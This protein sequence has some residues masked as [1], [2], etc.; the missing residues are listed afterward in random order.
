MKFN[1]RKIASVLTSAVML[2]STLA[3]AAAANY[4]APFVK[5]GNANVAI[6]YGSTAA[7]TDLVAVADISSHLSSELAKQTA[8]TGSSSSG[9]SVSGGDFVKLAKSSNNVNLR[10]TVSSVFG[11]IVTDDDLK[12]LLADGT[13]SND[14]NTEYDYE[15][16]VTLG[17]NLALTFFSDNDYKDEEATVG[18][19]LSSSETVLN[20]TLDFTT[21]AESDIVSGDLPDF[22]TTT[23][24]IL[25]K[26]Y[27][28]LDAKNQSNNKLTLLD[29]ANNAIVA[30]GETQTVTVGDKSYEVSIEFISTTQTKL[31]INGQVTNT[32]ANGGTY[33]LSDGT[34]VGVKDILARDVAGSVGKVEFSLGTG[35]LELTNAEAIELNDDSI[36]EIK[37]FITM[38]EQT[39]SKK[40][41]DKLVL[42]WM[43]DDEV[44]ITGD[45][46]ITMPGFNAL[47]LS[48]SDFFVP[49][50]E[51]TEVLGSSDY[52]QLKTTIKDGEVTI[53][54]LFAAS[55]GTAFSGIGKDSG[56]LLVTSNQTGG[57]NG[58]RVMFNETRGDEWLVASWN[59]SSEA[60]SYLLT[61]SFTS[62]NGINRTTVRKMASGSWADS[63]KDKQPG[64]TC[65]LGSL[66]LT[67]SEVHRN[68]ADKAVVVNGTAD[69]SFNKLYTSTGL[70]VALPYGSAT[71]NS[72]GG[73]DGLI[74]FNNTDA[75]M[76]SVGHSNVSFALVFTEENKEDDIAAGN[77][78]NVTIGLNSDTDLTVS[79]V[80]TG[81]QN[82]DMPGDD[83]DTVSRVSSDLATLV[84]RVIKT[85]SPSD[86]KIVYSGSEAYSDVFLTAVGASVSS[87]GSS[88]TT[89][90]TG[91]KVLGSVSVSDTEAASVSNRNLIVVGGSCING[92][93]AKLLG[94][95]LCGADFTETT[96]V[97][98][99]QFLIQTF[100]RTGDNVAT[101]VAGYHA[102]DTT[103]A[104][105]FL[106]SQ[107]VDTTVGKKYIGSSATSAQLAMA[108][109]SSGNS[110]A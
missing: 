16:K 30:E 12:V 93:A 19:N 73:A 22:E 7:N 81:R 89:T 33:K 95:A 27:Y 48:M 101:L 49:S 102:A 5:S 68:G 99:G 38:T 42:Q 26:E 52:V 75:S 18:F 36:E 91:V 85:G 59:S 44:F 23:L 58:G 92:E 71:T 64:D 54:L 94:G 97:G 40:K 6:V 9:T 67:I 3:L 37:A 98:A 11:S 35:K 105:K 20:Y 90:S 46:A 21:D 1:F 84:T 15:Q 57:G 100:A 41:F 82:F 25:G 29:T 61:F 51:T 104:A 78:F 56:N 72:T 2:S 55:A 86:A 14:E 10:D 76:S 39:G 96:K 24:K 110:T 17:N 34:Y 32:L 63:C 83:D 66:T 107:A 69:S 60:E 47:K 4:P 65:T 43:T 13:Y 74:S 87:D 109:T 31:K 77:K 45:Q 62:E 70:K 8:T 103:N 50:A 79:S 80:T 53:P 28:V 108:E 88:G 106:T